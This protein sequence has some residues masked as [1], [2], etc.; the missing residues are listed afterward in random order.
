MQFDEFA[1]ARLGALLRYA[2]VLTGDGEAA[3]D[4]VQEALT[5]AFVHWGRITAAEH[6]YAYV[7]MIV[8]NVYLSSRRRHVWPLSRLGGD[9]AEDPPAPDPTAGMAVRV[10]LRRALHALPRA[11]RAAIVLR[12][13][14]GL[15]DAE[16]AETLACR[17]ATVRS[18]IHRGL[19]ALRVNDHLRAE[20]GATP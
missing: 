9:A 20:E 15:T 13:F 6:P 7:R 2:T 1:A 14:E 10:D 16:I 17:P 3:R 5:R 12:Y 8:T 4:L 19:A 18:H 11:Q